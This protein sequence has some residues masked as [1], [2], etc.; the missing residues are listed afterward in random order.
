[1]TEEA[2]PA[3]E[4]EAAPAPEAAEEKPK[5]KGNR[6]PRK[7][8]FKD[9]LRVQKS[10]GAGCENV[11]VHLIYNEANNVCT[12]VTNAPEKEGSDVME[13]ERR[14]I[15]KITSFEQINV[16]DPETEPA[17]EPAPEPPP[18]E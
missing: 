16:P 5:K 9:W 18:A 11:V 3:P 6:A 4:P 8:S 13:G 12:L 15:F 14:Q 2:P 10:Q 7:P 1:M 17:P